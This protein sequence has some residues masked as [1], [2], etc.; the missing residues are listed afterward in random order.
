MQEFAKQVKEGGAAGEDRRV[1]KV[2]SER[3]EPEAPEQKRGIERLD[4]AAC[5]TLQQG[6]V[7]IKRE[8]REN[9]PIVAVESEPV[10]KR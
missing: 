10:D 2:V 6:L 4:R 3:I 8:S 5:E 7:G 1:D 9:A